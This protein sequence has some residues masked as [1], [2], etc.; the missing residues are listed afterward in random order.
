MCYFPGKTIPIPPIWKVYKLYYDDVTQTL[1]GWM[2]AEKKC[3]SK[4]P[5]LYY[6]YDASPYFELDGLASPSWMAA[7]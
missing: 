4:D 6:M 5:D 3:D 1:Q 7:D 2:L